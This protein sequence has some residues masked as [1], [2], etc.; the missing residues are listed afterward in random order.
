MKDYSPRRKQ[1]ETQI[2]ELWEG[3]TAIKTTLEQQSRAYFN[4]EPIE[5]DE[6]LELVGRA[7]LQEI[8]QLEEALGRI[9]NGSYSIYHKC[10]EAISAESL[11]VDPFTH[12][13]RD[14]ALP[15]KG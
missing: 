9:H 15:S 12:L 10:V 8:K 2:V 5:D 13:Y 7:G 4:D 1:I 14:C 3:V 11:N 6:V